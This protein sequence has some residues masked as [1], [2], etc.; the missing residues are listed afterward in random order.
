MKGIFDFNKKPLIHPGNKFTMNEK[1]EKGKS[2]Y[3]HG[4]GGMVL[5]TNYGTL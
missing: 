5:G 3:P 4:G 2:W 1:R